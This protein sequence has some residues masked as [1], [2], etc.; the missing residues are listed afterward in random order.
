MKDVKNAIAVLLALLQISGCAT[1]QVVQSVDADAGHPPTIERCVQD[2]MS[3]TN[4]SEEVAW[5]NCNLAE[6]N[7]N[8]GQKVLLAFAVILPVLLVL[9]IFAA[10][11]KTPT[12]RVYR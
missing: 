10:K 5:Q 7:R 8:T 6:N 12:S 4:A 9:N 3:T 11:S 1:T 2:T